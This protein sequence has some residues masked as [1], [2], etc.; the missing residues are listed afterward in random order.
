MPRYFK[1]D[2]ECGLGKGVAYFEFVGEWATRQVE[3]Y[4]DRWF[5]SLDDYYAELGPG[6]IDQ[7][8]AGLGMGPEHEISAG[9]FERVWAVA[10]TR[11]QP[12]GDSLARPS[13]E[14]Q[15]GQGGGQD[16]PAA[17]ERG[18]GHG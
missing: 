10:V 13:V 9:E 16:G 15:S 7:P 4:G 11:R 2:A 6:L 5:C 14:R 8:L 12:Q 17:S 3:V 1:R 18:V